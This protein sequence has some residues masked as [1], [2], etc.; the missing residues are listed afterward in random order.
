[1]CVCVYVCVCLCVCV[2]VCMYVYREKMCKMCGSQNEKCCDGVIPRHFKHE[3]FQ[4]NKFSSK[5]GRKRNS[6]GCLALSSQRDVSASSPPLPSSLPPLPPLPLPSPLPS[7]SHRTAS[8]HLWECG[9]QQTGSVVALDVTAVCGCSILT[10][11]SD[12][13]TTFAHKILPT[14]WSPCSLQ[15]HLPP[16]LQTCHRNCW[17]SCGWTWKN[18][19]FPS[20]HIWQWNSNLKDSICNIHLFKMSILNH[21]PES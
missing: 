2:C 20:A 17:M 16:Q 10:G 12:T 14:L 8:K 3:T 9:G 4:W 21:L 18:L 19:R 6:L 15:H 13:T 11:K 7:H 5:F 1:M